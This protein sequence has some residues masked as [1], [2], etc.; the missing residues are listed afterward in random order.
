MCWWV[1]AAHLGL[2]KVTATLGL[3]GQSWDGS[4][5]GY[6]ATRREGHMCSGRPIQRQDGVPTEAVG[7]LK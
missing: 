1:Q 6:G 7:G 2:L 5:T 4:A 3:L